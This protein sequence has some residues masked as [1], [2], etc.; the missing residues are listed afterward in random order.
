[1]FGLDSPEG[2]HEAVP[3]IRL[4][5]IARGESVLMTKFFMSAGAK[6]PPHDHPNEQIG[7]LL[8]GRITLRIG[9]SSR[10]VRPGDSWCVPSGV[11]HRA[12]IVEDSTALEIFSPIRADYLDYLNEADIVE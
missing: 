8:S 12:D 10:D 4:K 9:D 6:L 7:Y 11:A 2:F 3:G 1:M 5:T